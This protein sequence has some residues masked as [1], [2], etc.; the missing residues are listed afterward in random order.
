MIA[1]VE[2]MNMHLSIDFQH[3]YN[4]RR[5]IGRAEVLRVS[6]I[7]AAQQR[8]PAKVPS[9]ALFC[10]FLNVLPFHPAN[11][12]RPYGTW[13]DFTLYPALKCRA[14]VTT[15][16]CDGQT[17]IS[18]IDRAAIVAGPTNLNFPR[19][20]TRWEAPAKGQISLYR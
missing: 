20:P 13:I 9:G 11:L 19:K 2:L 1:P 12:S 10:F 17:P 15:S 18:V 3:F 5:M 16:L 4:N 7:E 6:H 8:R 14:I